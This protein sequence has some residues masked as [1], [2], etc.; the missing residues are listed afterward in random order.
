MLP[1]HE[2]GGS[3][4]SPPHPSSPPQGGE[5]FHYQPPNQTPM[6]WTMPT[7]KK[8]AAATRRGRI[9]AWAQKTIEVSQAA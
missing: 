8:T 2:K 1:E 4:G 6:P 3:C 5:G 7:G 9:F